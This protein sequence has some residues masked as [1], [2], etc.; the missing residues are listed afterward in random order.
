MSIWRI[1]QTR[2]FYLICIRGNDYDECKSK[3]CKWPR[4]WIFA[5]VIKRRDLDKHDVL[6]EIKYA[7]ICHSDIHT[8]R[9][10][11]GP[12]DYPL[13]PGHEIA[14]IVKEVGPEV[15]KYKVGDRVGVGCMVDSCGECEN[16]KMMKNNTV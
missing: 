13:V 2:I 7:G 12:V 15:T 10:E 3:S 8:A 1:I 4:F 14:G 11:W 9:E 5:T 16:C 6:I